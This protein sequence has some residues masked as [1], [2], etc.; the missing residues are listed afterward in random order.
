MTPREIADLLAQQAETVAAFLLPNGKRVGSCWQAGSVGGEQGRSLKVVLAGSKAG[1]WADH[2]NDTDHGDLL[3]LWAAVRGVPLADAIQ[4][5]KD[6][7]G[8]RDVRRIQ[9]VSKRQTVT[10]KPQKGVSRLDRDGAVYRYLTEERKLSPN[11]LDK[12]RLAELHTDKGAV[13]VFP[14][15]RDGER[16]LIKYLPLDRSQGKQPWTSKDSAKTLFG[17]QALDPNSRWVVLTEGEID[18]MTLAGFGIPALS[19]PYGAGKQSQEEWIE[20]DFDH[21]ERF[22]EVFI[23]ADDDDAGKETAKEIA[24]RLG[25]ERCRLVRTSHG[26]KDINEMAQK[27]C[28]EAHFRE[29][30]EA[31]KPLDPEYL[32][33]AA[34]YCDEVISEIYPQGGIQPGFSMGWPSVDWLRFRPAELIVLSGYNGHGKSQLGGQLI[35][36]AMHE[37]QRCCVASL[38]MPVRRVL[39]RLTKQAGA[40]GEPSREYVQAIH[41]WYAGKLWVYDHVGHTDVEEMLAAFTYARK[42]YG[43]TVFLID[44]LMMLSI[45]SDDYAGQKEFVQ[46]IMEWKMQH[47]TTVFLV[48][49]SR[50]QSNEE[51][52]PSKLDV[53]GAGEITDMADTVLMMWRDKRE[54]RI[55]DGCIDCC[56]QRNG[57]QEGEMAVWFDVGSN[58]FR[59]GSKYRPFRFV[60]FSAIETKVLAD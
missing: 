22:D 18:C 41:Q 30:L 55:T 21:L 46:R 42:R 53:R 56:K 17:W 13:I 2:A 36:N 44:S 25:V 3:D 39:A 23:W 50:K 8:V 47:N 12:F 51:H 16:V 1:R 20:N 33:S 38:E 31:A 15:L 59:P 37:G 43:V 40:T 49:H 35:L 6:Y 58:Q 57:D 32:R 34:E 29:C 26:A 48:A 14:F 45:A 9:P 52:R 19:I 4:Q 10:A 7:L 60:E 27:G 28:K 11:V 5:A 24:S 54:D